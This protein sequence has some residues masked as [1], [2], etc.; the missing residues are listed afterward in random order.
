[1]I[2][3]KQQCMIELETKRLLLRRFDE[4]DAEA[5]FMLNSDPQIVRYTAQKALVSV[6]ESMR[7]LNSED[8]RAD[9]KLGLGRFACVEKNSGRVVGLVGLKRVAGLDCVDIGFRFL[10]E[11]WGKGVATEAAAAVIK[12]GHEQLML[13]QIV[14]TVF[15]ENIASIKVLEKLGLSFQR[16]IR[17]GGVDAE[18]LLYA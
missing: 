12:Y 11:V 7:V 6:E 1:M 3:N 16:R 10:S 18:L 4:D 9:E 2:A 14:A 17:L 15:P 13:K 5:F 8:F